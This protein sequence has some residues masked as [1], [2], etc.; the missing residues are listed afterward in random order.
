MHDEYVFGT[1]TVE[2]EWLHKEL[3]DAFYRDLEVIG[4][5]G[6]V[7]MRKPVEKKLHALTRAIDHFEQREEYEKCAFI[8]SVLQAV[9][10]G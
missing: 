2:S 3:F 10:T 7:G 8:K 9:V 1:D 6:M 4:A 5:E